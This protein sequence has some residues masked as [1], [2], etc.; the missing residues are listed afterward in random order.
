MRVNPVQHNSLQS[1]NS[2]IDSAF[3]QG[4]HRSVSRRAE[5]HAPSAGYEIERLDPSAQPNP[6]KLEGLDRVVAILD[7]LSTSDNALSLAEI[8]HHMDLCKSTVHRA[9]MALERTGLIERAPAYR[10]RLGLKLYDMGHRAVEQIDLRSHAHPHLRKLALRV[11]ETVHLGVLHRS[12]IVYIDKIEPALPIRSTAPRWVKPFWLSCQRR[13][14]PGS[15]PL[16]S[17][18]R[19]PRIH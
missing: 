13:K 1:G 9:L 11:G 17:S 6:Y 18:K 19:L 8:C 12:R 5:H 15:L 14:Q 2:G 4:K 16:S 7:L 10:Y 3:S